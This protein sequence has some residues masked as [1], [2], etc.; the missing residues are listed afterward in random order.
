MIRGIRPE[1]AEYIASHQDGYPEA[2]R[3]DDPKMWREM[4]AT[5]PY[6]VGW[7][8]GEVL[9][10]WRI[11]KREAP[12]LIYAYDLTVLKEYQGRGL[13]KAIVMASL[14]L[15][16]WYGEQVHSHLRQ[17]SYHIVASPTLLREAG[18]EIVSDTLLPDH[19]FR[20]YDGLIHEDAHELYVKPIGQ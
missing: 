1:V 2:M 12:K 5:T 18:Y 11:F 7:F 17:T 9:V 6:S 16:R 20:E 15:P 8:D 19:Y 14:K 3:E 10:G 4:L 13:A